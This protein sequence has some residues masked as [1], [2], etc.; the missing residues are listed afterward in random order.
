MP[1][2]SVIVSIAVVAVFT[3]F[4]LVLA[5]AERVTNGRL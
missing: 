1:M 5:Y 2:E 4:G 3:I